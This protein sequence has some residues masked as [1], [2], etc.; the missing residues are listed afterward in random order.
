MPVTD[1]FIFGRWIRSLNI[2]VNLIY[3]NGCENFEYARTAL[4]LHADDLILKPVNFDELEETIRVIIKKATQ[5]QDTPVIED[6]ENEIIREVKNY[7]RTHLS[8]GITRKDAASHVNLNESY[9]SRLFR[10]ETGTTPNT[11]IQ[12][13]RI[14]RAKQLLI[15]TNESVT[16][17][18][19][20][21]GYDSTAYFIKIFKRETGQTPGE[22][23][24]EAR[25]R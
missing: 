11:Y 20:Q 22:F 18:G 15:T 13:Q 24:R 4:S 23:Q 3:M 9:F 12:E 6:S 16:F 8:E 21:A 14:K 5:K 1:G 17:I 10:R 7:I 19:E 2:P 25:K